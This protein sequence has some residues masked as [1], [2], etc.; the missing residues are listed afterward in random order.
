MMPRPGRDG[1]IGRFLLAL[2]DA[3]A[4]MVDERVLQQRMNLNQYAIVL[5]IT[6][7]HHNGYVV[8]GTP[9]VGVK[10]AVG[11]E[12]IVFERVLVPALI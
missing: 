1:A 9:D 7:I 8:I 3:R 12:V 10:L 6:E 11:D 2:G 5:G 4:D